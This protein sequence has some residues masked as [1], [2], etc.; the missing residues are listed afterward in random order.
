MKYTSYIAICDLLWEKRSPVLLYTLWKEQYTHNLLEHVLYSCDLRVATSTTISLDHYKADNTDGGL[1]VTPA[2]PRGHCTAWRPLGQ[3]SGS[4]CHTGAT[5]R[6]QT[7][8]VFPPQRAHSMHSIKPP[9]LRWLPTAPDRH[10][11]M[12]LCG[13]ATEAQKT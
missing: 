9:P 7:S 12:A 6:A 8:P 13:I 2:S 3:P 1:W 10:P 5:G 11:S 4:F